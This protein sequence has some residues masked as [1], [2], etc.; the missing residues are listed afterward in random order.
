MDVAKAACGVVRRCRTSDPFQ[1]CDALGIKLMY[2][3]MED[4]R[5][6]FLRLKRRSI[7]YLADNLDEYEQRF[8]CAHEVGHFI[9]HKNVNRLFMETRT[10]AKTS[11][12]ERE[13][14]RF[15]VWLLYPE[16]QA[17]ADWIDYTTDQ[18]AACMGVP[19]DLAQYRMEQIEYPF[20][21]SI[22]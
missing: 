9:L 13:A 8:V 1:L 17:L 6:L 15:A 5:G 19:E 12:Y 22:Y 7:I 21:L 18:I 2:L 20:N 11:V 16:D 3:P 14:D 4:V 10:Y